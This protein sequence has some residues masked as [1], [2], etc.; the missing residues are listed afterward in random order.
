MIPQLRKFIG[1][2]EQSNAQTI[3]DDV[4]K[5]SR[6]NTVELNNEKCKELH[7]SFAKVERDCLPNSNRMWKY[8]DSWLLGV[9]ISNDLTWSAHI[10]DVIRKASKKLYFF[11]L[12][13]RPKV[14]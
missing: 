12:L 8:Q 2:G 5:W 10:T 1:K 4:A 6:R 3:T 14:W 9:T 11:I 7:I 13:K